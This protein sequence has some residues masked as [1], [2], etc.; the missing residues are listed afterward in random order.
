MT[1]GHSPLKQPFGSPLLKRPL[2]AHRGQR[3]CGRQKRCNAQNDTRRLNPMSMNVVEPESMQKREQTGWDEQPAG[4]AG[5]TE[6]DRGPIGVTREPAPPTLLRGGNREQTLPR[7]GT[8]RTTATS[9]APQ[10]DPRANLRE[11]PLAVRPA[12]VAQAPDSAL[13]QNNSSSESSRG[14]RYTAHSKPAQ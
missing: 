7:C 5:A 8:F 3:C 2:S 6:P 9:S 1:A 14:V 11:S 12:A 4:D 10:S 13:R